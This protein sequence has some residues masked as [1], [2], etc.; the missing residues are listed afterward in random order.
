[1][2]GDELAQFLRR[3][4][5]RGASEQRPRLTRD[6]RSSRSSGRGPRSFAS[7]ASSSASTARPITC[8]ST[9]A[10]TSTTAL[11]GLFFRELGVREPD[12]QLGVRGT[13]FGDQ[14]GQILARCE[15]L[16]ADERPDTAARARRHEHRPCGLRREADGHPRGAHGGRQPLL[17]RPGSRGDQPAGH[18]SLELGPA[19][20][21]A[22]ERGK[23]R[24]GGHRAPPDVRDR[25]PDPRGAR[26]LRRPGRGRG[27]VRRPRRGAGSATSSSR[28]IVPR[29]STNQHACSRSSAR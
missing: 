9:P 21:Y 18:R 5:P 2:E 27:T 6:T 11:A 16:F 13:G 20:L 8:S 15:A 26:P 14:V 29:P 17:R 24:A 7:R 10:R 28:S 12:V 3:Q 1:M 19:S 22:Q 25:Q 23:P 4:D